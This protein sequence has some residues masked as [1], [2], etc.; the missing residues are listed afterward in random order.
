MRAVQVQHMEFFMREVTQVVEKGYRIA[1]F[2]DGARHVFGGVPQLVQ[3]E[4]R[5]DLSGLHRA[6]AFDAFQRRFIGLH[7]VFHGDEMTVQ[8]LGELV[9]TLVARGTVQNETHQFFWGPRTLLV[10]K[11]LIHKAGYL[12]LGVSY[13]S[14]VVA[15]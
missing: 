2:F 7:E 11:I 9:H 3:L 6:D 15:N 5:K 8:A 14:S 1:G 13:L 12:R 4:H 10:R